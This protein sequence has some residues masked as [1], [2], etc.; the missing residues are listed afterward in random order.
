[1]QVVILAAGMGKR[2]KSKTKNHTKSMVEILGKTF[3]EHSL[4]KL[5]K[6][7]I[8][9]II[10]VIGYCGDEIQNVIGNSYNGVPVIYVENKDYATTNNIYSLY[11]TKPYLE[12]EDTLLLE[13]DLIYDESIIEKLLN[14]PYKNLAVVDKFKP[15]M[16]GTVVKINSE[17]E[18]VSFI[19]KEH[20]EFGDINS[21][22]KTVNIYKFSKEFM[23]KSYIPFLEAYCKTMGTNSYYELVL[24]V[25]LSLE[26]NDLRVLRLEGEK[27]YEVDD[28]QDYDIAETMFCENGNE[29]L[30]KLHKRYGGYWRFDGLK[31]FCYLVNPYFPNEKLI[32]ELK[33]NFTELLINYPSG[34]SVEKLLVANIWGI[35]EKYV[36]VGN[37]AAELINSLIP[38]IEGN[39]GIVLPTFQEYPARVKESSDVR[40]F[41]PENSDF[42]YNISDLKNFS[43]KIDTLVLINPDN[44]SGNFIPKS[45]VLELVQYFKDNNK[46]LI[47]DES[48]VDFSQDS[49]F[50]TLLNNE[51]LKE[52]SNLTVI[53]SI[54]KSYGVPGLRL[55]IM[56]TS[57]TNLLHKC[58]QNMPVWNINSFGEYFL[59]ILNKHK[60][61]Y[62]SA[63]QKIA[64]NREEFYTQLTQIPFLRPI[65][66]QANYI[67]CEVLK[68][69]TSA[70]LCQELL[71]ANI[72]IKD[73]QNKMGF[74][75]K[76]YIRIAV[77]SQQDNS[78]LISALEKLPV[79]AAC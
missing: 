1:M 5:T 68:P 22:Y 72:L 55:G 18:I 19:P 23:V 51:I 9:K 43:S 35:D 65:K 15:W 26:K 10:I 47:L 8:S 50:N 67:L 20:F 52:Y 46:N 16:D 6:F 74:D 3:L 21:Y 41:I 32:D 39:I 37:G 11:L 7:D 54:S 17:D 24:K 45:D 49:E 71:K 73:C 44:P 63:C 56:A 57:N 66:S 62:L 40:Y 38:A 75:G 14:N 31:D 29:K 28:L 27:W 60:K 59:Q 53:K 36:L 61:H 13:S 76:Q 78:E 25:L 77:K 79:L 30:E 2:L 42:S 70:E 34:Q 33:N 69:Y 64:R 58:Y 48:F 4:D 12:Q